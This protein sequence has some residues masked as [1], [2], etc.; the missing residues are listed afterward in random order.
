MLDLNVA[1]IG[2]TNKEIRDY[3]NQA[4][5][6]LFTGRTTMATSTGKQSMQD[7]ALGKFKDYGFNLVEPDDHL[8]E[9]WFKDK[10]IAVYYQATATIKIIQDGCKNYLKS[11]AGWE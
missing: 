3:V 4:T 5:I 8:L 6:E 2:L 1:I 10:R 11:I 9:L 7:E